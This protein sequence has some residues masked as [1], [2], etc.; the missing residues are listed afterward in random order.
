M[1]HITA[2]SKKSSGGTP[3]H[4]MTGRV[5]AENTGQG[6]LDGHWGAMRCVL[7][8]TNIEDDD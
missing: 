6:V 4:G 8:P 3:A 1:F 7:K 2:I 5:L